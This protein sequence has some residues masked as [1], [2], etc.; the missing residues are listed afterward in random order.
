MKFNKMI[1]RLLIMVM[2]SVNIFIFQSCS[3]NVE[4]NNHEIKKNISLIVKMIDSDYWKTVKMGA[5]AAAKEFNINVHFSAPSNEADIKGQ[6]DMVE[7]AIEQ[8]TDALILAASDYEALT[9]VTENAYDLGIPVIAIDSEINSNNILSFIATDNRDAGRKAA[10]EL[11]KVAGKKCKVAIMSSV[12]GTGNAKQREEGLYEVL[13]KYP[14]IEVITKEYCLS[15][16]K[17]ASEL[18]KKIVSEN[19]KVDAFIALND[20]SSI[21]VAEAVKGMGLTGKVKVIAFDSTTEEIG[22]LEDGVIQATIVQNPFNI[23]YLSVKYAVGAINGEKIPVRVDTG[24]KII[25]K[26]N[27]YLTENQKL[28]FPFVK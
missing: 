21:G 23:G 14:E 11:V 7:S 16:T 24:A 15:D 25:N 17:Y 6:L 19:E 3:G 9:S 12:K 22:Y 18:T 4:I 13:Y 27:I 28:L 20:K 1:L 5:D 10:N 26:D 2:I 8:K